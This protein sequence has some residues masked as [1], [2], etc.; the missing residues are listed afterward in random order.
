MIKLDMIQTV[1]TCCEA[2]YI[3]LHEPTVN[4]TL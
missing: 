3:F 1:D 2:I 4:D